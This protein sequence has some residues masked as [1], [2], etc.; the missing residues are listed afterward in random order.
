MTAQIS[1]E[2]TAVL[3]A[4]LAG[5][6]AGSARWAALALAGRR[7]LL[8]ELVGTVSAAAAEWVRVACDYKG[9]DESSP[10]RGEEWLSGPYAVLTALTALADSLR[11]LET[12]GSAVDGFRKGTG[13]GGRVTVDVLPHTVFDR[14]L[15][16]GFSAQVWMRPG[17]SREQLRARAG[18]GQRTPTAPG[19]VGLVLGAGNITAI[20][21]LDVL[22]ELHAH[23][24]V[25]LLKLNPVT[26]PLLAV[27]RR[28]FAPLVDAGFLA[29]VSGGAEVGQ[30]LVHAD[31]ISHVHITGS[32]VS[33]NAIVFGPGVEGAARRSLVRSGQAEPLLDKEITSELGGVSPVIVVPGQWSTADL[34]YQAE[35]IATQRLHN[36]GYNCIAT[37]GVLLSADW[38]QREAFLAELRSALSAAPLR[39]A[40]YPGSEQR[41]ASART[42]YPRAELLTGDRLLVHAS[43]VL[44]E[45]ALTTEYFAPVL[46][47]TELPGTGPG[48]LRAAVA[49]ANELFTGTLGVNVIAHPR[50]LRAAG[51]AFDEALADLRYGT[52][53]VNCWTG[54]GFLTARAP[55]GA[56]P[57]ATL[58][59]VQSGIGVVHNALL[60][61]DTE[62]TIVRGPFRP[63]HRSL[64]AG[65]PTLSPR[66][67]WFVTNRTAAVS[68]RLLT[69]FA[70][71]PRWSKLPAIFASAL[72]G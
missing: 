42:A 60:L 65:E 50:T 21:L 26:D 24:R 70:A 71:K 68:G 57:G 1:E 4:A 34:R 10:L 69:E 59:D 58:D 15:L 6:T 3:D 43:P 2:T 27:F 38:P 8:E 14:L 64:D 66:P 63:A 48:F 25:S 11:A 45:K 22:Y 7:R 30:H 29:V 13:P 35:H 44:G 46:A 49:A 18:L 40:Y 33:H 16:G 62:R 28:A 72:R 17:V 31:G 41:I 67:P 5:L 39:P 23:N 36:G 20:P 19:G 61:A 52:I 47:V 37:Q 12:G 32:A 9:L 55:W 54:F 53:A 56:F 51:S